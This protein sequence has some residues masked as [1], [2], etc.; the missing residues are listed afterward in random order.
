AY[1]LFERAS[2]LDAHSINPEIAMLLSTSQLDGSY[3]ARLFRK[4]EAKLRRTGGVPSDSNSLRSLRRCVFEER[5]SFRLADL[6]P[7]YKAAAQSANHRVVVEAAIFFAD[8]LGNGEV[9]LQ[10]LERASKLVPRDPIARLNYI[11][12]LSALGKEREAAALLENLE[13]DGVRS[14]TV[15]R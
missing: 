12:A 5:C 3:D 14:L 13:L 8:A 6:E 9:A 4:A 15:H 10:L 1:E 11:D 2:K 7:M